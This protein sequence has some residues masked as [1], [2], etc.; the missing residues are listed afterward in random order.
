MR[1]LQSADLRGGVAATL[2][3]F[4]SHGMPEGGM[5]WAPAHVGA[6]E[7]REVHAAPFK[8]AIQSADAASVMNAYHEVDG[9]PL[10]SSRELLVDFLR[11]ELGF[12]GVLASD[13]FTVNT[14]VEYHK[15]AHDKAEA[16]E[17]ALKA[18]VDLELPSVN[19]YGEPLMKALREGKIDIALVEAGAARVLALKFRMGLFENPFV[20]TGKIPEIY[21]NPQAGQLSREIAR[22]SIVLLKNHANLLP[23]SP[24]LKSIAV[25]GP[26]ADSARAMQGDYHFPS[27]FEG[28]FDPNISP[29]APS[30]A[31]TRQ[32]FDWESLIPSSITVL[33]GIKRLVSP[34]THVIY[35][36]G[37]EH[38]GEDR[39]GFSAAVEAAASADVAVLVVGDKSG[40]SRPI[41]ATSGESIDNATLELPGVQ[42]ELIKAVHKTGKP[43]VVVLLTGRAYNLSWLDANVPSLLEAWFPAEQGGAAIADILFGLENPGGK[44]PVSF[45]RHVGQV[46]VF[47]AHKPSGGRSNWWG[48]Y[49]NMPTTPL[50]PFGHGLSYTQFAYADLKVEPAQPRPDQTVTVSFTLKNVGSCVGDEVPQLYLSDP[51][52]TVTRPVKLLKGF[53]RVTLQPSEAKRITF[54]LDVRHLAFYDREM[55]YVVEPGQITVM[56]GSSAQ[57]IRLTGS[58][59]IVGNT[60][61]VEQVFFT[62]A[63][64][65]ALS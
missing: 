34:D 10:G 37:C 59:E 7:L 49:I 27:H 3:H 65:E 5:N 17:F 16:A 56:I 46:P 50:Y 23:L 48:D 57:D 22:K 13:Y 39:S 20:D 54:E 14:F 45:P 1:G 11:G 31:D 15:I 35:A 53:T 44:L 33:E 28:I 55:C 64:S 30:P 51:I 9:I 42:L 24:T 63:R 60:T 25:I 2:K 58:F 32:K 4:L 6:R 52:A 26:S 38:S 40:L 62:P 43:M 12:D 8:A 19:C 29:D 41:G 21:G 61:P 47:Y 36:Q 18:A